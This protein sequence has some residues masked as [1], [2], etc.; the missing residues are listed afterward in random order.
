[1]VAG[2]A[3]LPLLMF[4][5]AL[6]I[7]LGG[8]ATHPELDEGKKIAGQVVLDVIATGGVTASIFGLLYVLGS[9][10]AAMSTCDSQALAMGQIVSRDFVRGVVAPRISPRREMMSARVAIVSVFLVAYFIGMTESDIILQLSIV[11]GSGT[12]ILVPTYL[13]IRLRHPSRKAAFASILGGYAVFIAGEA[14]LQK[15]CFWAF[16]TAC[17]RLEWLRYFTSR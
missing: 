8:A 12:A 14:Y 2:M 11:S 17:S 13:G 16:T 6:I 5:P 1:M 15:N 10:S 4:L 9:L 7:G 3:F